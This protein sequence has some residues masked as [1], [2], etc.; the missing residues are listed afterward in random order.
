[1]TEVVTM[2]IHI[3][4]KA[5]GRQKVDIGVR[6]DAG[7]VVFSDGANLAGIE[8]R[9][10]TANNLCAKLREL[11]VERTPDEL[12]RELQGVWAKFVEAQ[13]KEAAERAKSGAAEDP[14][15]RERRRLEAMPAEGRAKAEALRRSPNLMNGWAAGGGGGWGWGGGGIQG[16]AHPGGQ[17]PQARPACRGA[18][19]RTD[20]FG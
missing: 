15:A 18:R 10:K 20:G 13:E 9:A 12:E 8:G 1:F 5:A 17:E 16:A 7:C 6:D 4:I 14:D 19:Q 3:E 2:E 11:G